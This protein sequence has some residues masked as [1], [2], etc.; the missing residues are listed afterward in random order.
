[1]ER[2]LARALRFA[3]YII[4]AILVVVPVVFLVLLVFHGKIINDIYKN[5][6]DPNDG[7]MP[8]TATSY[9]SGPE[10]VG[11][12]GGSGEGLN[13]SLPPLTD[14][15]F[16]WSADQN[17]NR[18]LVRQRF[19]QACVF[20]DLCYRHGL[21]TYGYTQNDCDRILQNQAY[22]L[23]SYIQNDPQNGKASDR[24]QRDAKKVLAGVNLGGYG[25][26]RGWDR[27]TYFEFDSSPMR[28]QEFAFS[29]VVSHPFKLL[30]PQ[31]YRGDPGEVILSFVNK[32][33]HLMVQCVNCGNALVLERSDRP[34][35]VSAEFRASGISIRPEALIGRALSLNEGRTIWLPRGPY[36]GSPHLVTGPEGEHQLVWISRTAEENTGACL[37][38]TDAKKLLTYTLPQTN[39]CNRKAKSPLMLAEVETYSSSPQPMVLPDSSR[40]SGDVFATGLSVQKDK[41]RNLYFCG[42]SQ[43]MHVRD[44]SDKARCIL[45]KEDTNVI[46][47]EI[48]AFQNFAT[49]RPGQQMFFV[50]DIAA[51]PESNVL[52]DLIERTRGNPY[53]PE[54]SFLALDVRGNDAGGI[55]DV[56]VAKNTRFTIDDSYDPMM[57]ISAAKDDFRFLSVMSSAQGARLYLTNFKDD[58]PT[59]LP[60]DTIMAGETITL[61]SSWLLRPTLVVESK[62]S[63]APRTRLVVSRGRVFAADEPNTDAAQFE[64]LV[65]DRNASAGSET[66][67]A[68][69]QAVSC[70]VKYTFNREDPNRACQRAF[71]A[72]RPMRSSPAAMINAAQLLAGRVTAS[73]QLSLA[74]MDGCFDTDPILFEPAA[75][76][77]SRT[78]TLTASKHTVTKGGL[79]RELACEPLSSRDQ[80]QNELA[81]VGKAGTGR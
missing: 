15:L 48:G 44:G 49:I 31:K 68:V 71:F 73:N 18:H 81:G 28:S 70:R 40:G 47:R 29:R 53:S 13:C 2:L 9:V 32:R 74:L 17:G 7:E 8:I 25:S 1:M 79:K 80:I 58:A 6:S 59:P 50:R 4:K 38:K 41:Y 12:I 37:V 27:S 20:H 5:V 21:A 64:A 34:Q 57:P 33:S 77:N 72:A 22:R 36:H 23:C 67:F 65:F 76:E 46:G 54:G 39:S 10:V 60:I 16:D 63:A 69:S 61:H 42:W 26:Y 51:R 24:C 19:R 52:I 14:A 43:G 75:G 11:I 78:G 35:D 30:D 55:A 66:P 62:G 45:L 3:A 56:I